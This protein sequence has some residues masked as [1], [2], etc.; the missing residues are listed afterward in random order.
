MRALFVA[1]A[2]LLFV[3]PLWAKD[4]AGVPFDEQLVSESGVTLHLNGAGIRKKL[5]FKIYIAALY[6]ANPSEDASLVIAD[7]KEKRIV[8]HFL[9]DEVGKDKLIEAWNEGFAANQGEESLGSLQSRIDT[10]NAMFDED[11]VAG[12]V[13]VFDYFPGTGTRVTI[14]GNVE[15]VIEGK[16]FNDALL[17]IWLGDKPVGSDLKNELLSP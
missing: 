15:G 1:F 17:A 12:D 9:Y 8:M 2:F 7:E 11:M 5:F 6:L 4:I 16:D 3:N 10:F 14:K 13:I